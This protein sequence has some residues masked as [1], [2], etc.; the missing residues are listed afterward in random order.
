MNDNFFLILAAI[1]CMPILPAFIIYKFLPE[2]ETQVDGPYSKLNLKLKGAFAGYF[3]L[4]IVGVG[5]QWA[6]MNNAQTKQIESLTRAVAERDSAIGIMKV[7]MAA[8]AN[9]VIDWRVK[10]LVLPGEKEGTR[11]FFDDGTTTKSPDGS[12]ELIKRTLTVMGKA[13]PPKWIC[14]YNP[15]AGYR[16]VSLNRD[17]NHPDIAAFNVAF[18]DSAHEILIRKPININS[19]E[20]DSVVA[21]AGF[22]NGNPSLKTQVEA[23][24]PQI[25]RKAEALRII[26]AVEKVNHLPKATV[27]AINGR[28]I[29]R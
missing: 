5:L 19:A 22:L 20:E 25:F 27:Q 6:V 14:V 29:Q 3:L 18:N 1:L 24:N 26:K 4:V 23:A 21:V 13:S 2:S 8:S 11:F 9:P 17:V 12:F 15:L 10:G 28:R 16:V 7:S